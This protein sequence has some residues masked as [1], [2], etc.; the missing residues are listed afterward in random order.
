MRYKK[1]R[2][3]RGDATI[4]DAGWHFSYLGG[5]S[6]IQA[7]ISSWSHTEFDRAPYNTREHIEARMKAGDDLFDRGLQYETVDDL[8]YLP[9]HALSNMDRYSKYLRK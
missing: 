8:S 5:V 4:R 7:K 2:Y 6:A 1:L 9:Q 3:T